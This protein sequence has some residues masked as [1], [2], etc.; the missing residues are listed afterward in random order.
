MR[1]LVRSAS[2]TNYAD[3][4]AKARLDPYRLL[5]EFRLPQRCLREPELKVPIDAVRG[6]LEASAERSGIEAFGLLMAE[7]RR[8]SNLGP[9]G[10]LVREQPTLRLAIEALARYANRLNEALFL[11]LEDAGDVVVLREELIVGKTGSVRQS[12]ELAIGV[13]FT[14]LKGLLGPGWKP[15]RV[16]FAHDAPVDRSVHD[17][18][19]GRIVEFGHDFNGIV[20]LRKD[21]EA[22]N[23]NADALMARYAQ[24]LVEA[25]YAGKAPDMTSQ[26][27]QLV[28]TLL[29]T[30]NCTID[31][32]AKHLGVTRRTIHRH[33]TQE[34]KTFS[35]IVEAVRRELAARYVKDKHRS[36]AEVSSLLGF[37]AP[38]GFS[39]W[40]R[41]E[42]GEAASEKR[43]ASPR[44]GKRKIVRGVH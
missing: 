30:G 19:F 20:C 34:G 4:A 37:A 9:L 43:A 2:L 16:C 42:F 24:G 32:A 26:V 10:L 14:I 29:S 18:V 31:L 40:Y 27:R 3:V 44:R 11:T 22:R 8:L 6:L 28:V 38:S 5:S 41:R 17:R 33:L 1:G 25:N 21:L 35:D 36:L 15:R 23:P 39:R 13:A 7:K 12:T